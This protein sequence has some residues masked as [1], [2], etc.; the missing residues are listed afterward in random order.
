MI[1][2]GRSDFDALRALAARWGGGIMSDRFSRELQ[3]T[4][5]DIAA[6]RRSG[7]DFLDAS[8]HGDSLREMESAALA[9][10]A[11]LY[12]RDAKLEVVDTETIRTYLRAP[13]ER[14]TTHVRVRCLNYEEIR[15]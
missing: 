3:G 12:G 9:L 8:V 15:Q 11:G 1:F 5:A 14:F 6:R 10:A 4:L 7:P 2:P 13:G